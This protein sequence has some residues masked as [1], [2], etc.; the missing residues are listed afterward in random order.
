MNNSKASLKLNVGSGD[1]HVDGFVSVDIDVSVHPDI[2]APADKLPF[3]SASVDEITAFHVIEHVYYWEAEATIREWFR[4]LAPG[5][6]LVIECPDLSKVVRYLSKEQD[7]TTWS[8]LG[9]WGVYGDPN[10]KN[11][12]YGHR[13]GYTENSISSL[14]AR[15]GF[16]TPQF[17]IPKT[18]VPKRDLRV[19]AIKP[20][21]TSHPFR[22][23]LPSDQVQ[24]RVFWLLYGDKTTG[25]SRLHGYH[26]NNYLRGR[27]WNS[28]ILLEPL[29]PTL[30]IPLSVKEVRDVG[31][32][33]RGDIVIVQKL[34]DNNAISLLEWLA[35]NGVKTIYL[36][37]DMPLK[38]REASFALWTVCVSAFQAQEY[39]RA[40]INHVVYIP[41]A[42]ESVK[43]PKPLQPS[44][45]RLRCVWFGSWTPEKARDIEYF[46]NLLNTNGFDDIDLIVISD[47]P[48]ATIQW[49]LTTVYEH[50]H[51]CDFAVIPLQHIDEFAKAK[52]SNRAVQ[53]MALGLPVLATPIP[54][55]EEVIQS[56]W[57]GFL[58]RND[59]EWLE[60]LNQMR[61]P[62]LRHEIAQN[63]FSFSQEFFTI[64]SIG[65]LWETFLSGIV[66]D[67]NFASVSQNL[68]QMFLQRRMRARM[69][70]RL[71]NTTS[72]PAII[73]KYFLR[74]LSEYPFDLTLLRATIQV[75]SRIG[76]KV[77]SKPFNPEVTP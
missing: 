42:I 43:P 56:G 59:T 18:H 28:Q 10:H 8:N 50:L 3:R 46:Q 75:I 67:Q 37:S 31:L 25:S 53:A 29:A 69:S 35:G 14:L 40:G 7:Y 5:G 74:S 34:S 71:M 66:A 48:D 58:C 12:F 63:S 73:A 64:E 21:R 72:E 51:Q 6:K 20:L 65:A 45:T 54:A 33:C 39:K 2:V 19:E 60:A 57:N 9:M 68:K 70:A 26:L 15:A 52:S 61:D 23:N 44:T 1:T 49:D 11:P 77:N 13:W 30:Q 16:L 17:T 22:D 38:R 47:H 36:D 32:L 27:G 62:S 4:V 55:Y 41:D 76:H 24:P